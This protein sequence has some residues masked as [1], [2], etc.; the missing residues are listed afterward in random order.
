MAKI[1]DRIGEGQYALLWSAAFSVSNERR[2]DVPFSLA[3]SV[4]RNSKDS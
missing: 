1:R 3:A 2:I 4:A